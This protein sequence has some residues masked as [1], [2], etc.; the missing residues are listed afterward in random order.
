MLI[1]YA[2][3]LSYN[4][5]TGN[6]DRRRGFG[7]S[8]D[9]RPRPE[10]RISQPSRTFS[11]SSASHA[12][13]KGRNLDKEDLLAPTTDDEVVHFFR[14]T[15]PPLLFPE[16]VALRMITHSTWKY[17]ARGHNYRLSFI[18]TLSRWSRTLLTRHVWSRSTSVA[19]VP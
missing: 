16:E 2:C 8:P 18:G 11:S 3:T 1:K 15:L 4:L 6:N 9:T 5:S 19:C 7:T 12:W 14:D 10:H 17:G 13:A